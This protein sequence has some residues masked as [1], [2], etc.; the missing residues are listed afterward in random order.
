MHRKLKR[1]GFQEQRFNTGEVE[2]N[3]VVGPNN[4]PA[5]VLIPGQALSWESYQRVLPYLAKKFQSFAVDIRGHGKSGWTPGAYSFPSMGRDMSAFLAHVVSRPAII[6]GN[7]SGGL[8]AL[9]LAANEPGWVRGIILEDTPVFSAEWPRLRDDCWVYR[10]FK[11]NS[12]T[13]GA[14]TGRDLAAF[15]K[16]I[17]VPMEGKQRVIRFPR[18]VGSILAGI[19]RGYQFARPGHPVDIPLLPAEV[20]LMTKCLSVYDPDFT[21][22]FVDGSACAGFNHAE[23]LSRVTC[24]VLLLQANS[25]RHPEYGLVGSMDDSDIARVRSLVHH[26]QYKRITSGHMIHFEEPK[27]FIHEVDE[28]AAHLEDV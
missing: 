13:I 17:E 15:F 2:L 25:F 14:P 12:E 22:A 16:D 8:I 26:C 20:R 18:W 24:P 21:R 27:E 28:F 1:A 7:S 10:I 19:I 3:Y 11:R 9:W 23:A 4:G 5:L 6:S